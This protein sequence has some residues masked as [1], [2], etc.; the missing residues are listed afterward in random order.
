M[1]IAHGQYLNY[2]PFTRRRRGI[3]DNEGG[4]R[5]GRNQTAWHFALGNGRYRYADPQ[6]CGAGDRGITADCTKRVNSIEDAIWGGDGCRI[7][8]IIDPDGTPVEL[9]EQVGRDDAES[10]TRK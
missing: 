6:P 10:M 2:S 3:P 4:V 5:Y 8:W 9:M 1:K 7:A